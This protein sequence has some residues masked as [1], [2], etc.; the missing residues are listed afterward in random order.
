MRRRPTAAALSR[1]HASR[2]EDFFLR[3]S[4]RVVCP[5]SR[6]LT[7]TSRSHAWASGTRDERPV[8]YDPTLAAVQAVTATLMVTG[9]G[10]GRVLI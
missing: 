7:M 4:R 9:Y 8:I 1:T 5:P 2:H 10:I 3:G 6:T